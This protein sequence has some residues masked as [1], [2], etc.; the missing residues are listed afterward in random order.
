VTRMTAFWEATAFGVICVGHD[1]I[2]FRVAS[3]LRADAAMRQ[4]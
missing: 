2:P 3:A 1:T 4:G